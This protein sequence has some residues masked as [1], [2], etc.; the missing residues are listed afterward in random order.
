MKAASDLVDAN[1]ICSHLA[2]HPSPISR[3]PLITGSEP[4]PK[5]LRKFHSYKRDNT[6]SSMRAW[7]EVNGRSPELKQKS[8]C[9]FCGKDIDVGLNVRRNFWFHVADPKRATSAASVSVLRHGGIQSST[10]LLA[11]SSRRQTIQQ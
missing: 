5:F 10:V 11:G 3:H 6:G 7:C 9:L 8:D 4:L 2:R 1:F